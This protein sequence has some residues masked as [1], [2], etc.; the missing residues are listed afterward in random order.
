MFEPNMIKAKNFSNPVVRLKCARWIITLNHDKKKNILFISRRLKNNKNHSQI[1]WIITIKEIGIQKLIWQ[2]NA[3]VKGNKCSIIISEVLDISQ[4][5]F[6][7]MKS[8][9]ITC[10]HEIKCNCKN[11]D[12]KQPNYCI[13]LFNLVCQ[14]LLTLDVK[15][16]YLKQK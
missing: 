1:K 16:N 10:G 12:V 2:L 4:L 5:R 8:S 11:A 15:Q 13:L 14:H 9:A 3:I 6:T 7:F